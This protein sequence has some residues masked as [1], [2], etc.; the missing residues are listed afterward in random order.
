MCSEVLDGGAFEAKRC[1]IAICNIFHLLMSTDYA[2]ISLE[3]FLERKNNQ[4]PL[5]QALLEH[6]GVRTALR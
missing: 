1:I 6:H 2:F 3:K 4:K 5:A